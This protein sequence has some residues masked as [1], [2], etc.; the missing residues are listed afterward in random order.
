MPEC[1]LM[2]ILGEM[3]QLFES[4]GMLWLAYSVPRRYV[5]PEKALA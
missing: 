3:H 5:N 1:N 2:L 4:Y